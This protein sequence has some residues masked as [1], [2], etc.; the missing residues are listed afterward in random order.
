MSIN[1]PAY[2]CGPFHFLGAHNT[3]DPYDVP[4]SACTVLL[5]HCCKAGSVVNMCSSV[6]ISEI[7][8]V[9]GLRKNPVG[10]IQ[11]WKLIPGNVFRKK[12]S[13]VRV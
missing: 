1:T 3:D 2:F 13:G 5:G 11:F 9:E 12:A 7:V 4:R 8:E 6:T 10:E